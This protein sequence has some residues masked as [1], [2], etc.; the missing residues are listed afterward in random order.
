M[1]TDLGCS[2]V[3]NTVHISRRVSAHPDDLN[4][5]NAARKTG[6]GLAVKEDRS[7]TDMTTISIRIAEPRA[8][9]TDRVAIDTLPTTSL[10][11]RTM[12]WF[13][14]TWCVINGGHFKVLHT[15]P[16]KL[17]LRCVACGHMSPGWEVGSPRLARRTPADPDRLRVRR[18]IAA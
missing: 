2:D 5:K 17:A 4:H 12:S 7:V 10:W 3:G 11:T 14:S 6:K 8:R 16:D 13:R 18:A 15:E 9:T 1:D